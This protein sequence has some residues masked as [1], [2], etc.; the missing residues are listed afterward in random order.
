LVDSLTSNPSRT[1]A[2]VNPYELVLVAPRFAN[3]AAGRSPR[4]DQSQGNIPLRRYA[5]AMFEVVI[6]KRSTFKWEWRVC[7]R[8]GKA[9]IWLG[10]HP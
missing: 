7:D 5:S 8:N 1:G 4:L 3:I 9:I 6:I 10:A 2:S